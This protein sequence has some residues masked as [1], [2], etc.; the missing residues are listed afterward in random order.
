MADRL[1][2][3]VRHAK[4]GE[5]PGRPDIDRPL[6][7]RGLR[8]AAAAGERLRDCGVRL[9][10]VVCSTA[11]RTQ[12]TWAELATA[13]D[14]PEPTF[15]PRVYDADVPTLL[16][17]LGE[18]PDEVAAAALVGHNPGMH[19]LVATLTDSEVERFP[20]CA[21]ALLD[22]TDGWGDLGTGSA[23]LRTLHLPR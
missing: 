17:V 3:V 18:I 10:A 9:D 11:R 14:G 20:T 7:P 1:L 15:D 12:Q 13:L 21:I 23:A 19:A 2:A 5:A 8:D 4:A 22:L 6:A 16:A